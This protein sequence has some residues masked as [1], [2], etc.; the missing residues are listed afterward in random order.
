MSAGLLPSISLAAKAR[1]V[2]IIAPGNGIPQPFQ[3]ERLIQ[4]GRFD[5]VCN[6]LGQLGAV[7][8]VEARSTDGNGSFCNRGEHAFTS[9]DRTAFLP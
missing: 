5:F 6:R 1:Q 7:E 8:R 9:T 4:S 3:A 2:S